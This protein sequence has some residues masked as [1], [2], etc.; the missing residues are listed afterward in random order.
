MKHIKYFFDV[1]RLFF[2]CFYWVVCLF[3]KE[4]RLN[5]KIGWDTLPHFSRY[6]YGGLKR[7]EFFRLLN[8]SQKRTITYEEYVLSL[9][10]TSRPSDEIIFENIDKS[11]LRKR[12]FLF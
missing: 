9:Y 10:G 4:K 7:K 3:F 1:P 12:L 6:S 8:E 11:L 2:K 5:H